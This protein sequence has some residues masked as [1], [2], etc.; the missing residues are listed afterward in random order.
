MAP[1]TNTTRPS[2][3]AIIRPPTA[4]RS[5]STTMVVPG[6]HHSRRRRAAGRG[7]GARAARAAA[8]E[9]G[10]PLRR[11][12]PVAEGARSRPRPRAGAR[13]G[14]RRTSPPTAARV[15]GASSRWSWAMSASRAAPRAVRPVGAQRRRG[16]RRS[17]TSAGSRAAGDPAARAERRQ[18]SDGPI[19]MC[20]VIERPAGRHVGRAGQRS[21]RPS[22]RRAPTRRAPRARRPRRTRPASADAG[23]AGAAAR[24]TTRSM[25]AHATVSG[26]PDSA[27]PFTRS[28][29]GPTMRM[30]WP[31]LRR[32]RCASTARQ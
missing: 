29:A 3:R 17:A 5:T 14:R 24:S 11:R 23:R 12:Q 19:S 18:L 2:W 31:P 7:A 8:S 30:R 9:R 1:A 26:M 27:Q 28:N 6:P 10:L 13:R 25:P 22:R 21:P 15:S 32:Q 16:R 20:W 4:G